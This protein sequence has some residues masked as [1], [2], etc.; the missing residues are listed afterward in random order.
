MRSSVRYPSGCGSSVS[1]GGSTLTSGM[2][3]TYLDAVLE[4]VKL[5]GRPWLA[6]ASS[7][8]SCRPR[9]VNIRRRRV[10]P[11]ERQRLDIRGRSLCTRG[12][13]WWTG[14]LPPSRSW[15][16]DSQPGRLR[17]YIV[18]ISVWW[19]KGT[20]AHNTHDAVRD[21]SKRGRASGRRLPLMLIT[22][23]ILTY[24]GLQE[25]RRSRW[26]GSAGGCLVVGGNWLGK[27]SL[28]GV[29]GGWSGSRREIFLLLTSIGGGVWCLH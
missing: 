17:G 25:V 28:G 21:A 7:K 26:M 19:Q 23:R 22:S 9:V 6:R 10:K 14:D 5:D 12:V 16:F 1:A 8:L 24:P 2:S 15:L 18:S 3:V 11:E 29:R 4:A 27:A 20:T 13:L